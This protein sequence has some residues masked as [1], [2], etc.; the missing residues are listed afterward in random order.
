MM[1]EPMLVRALATSIACCLL[2]LAGCSAIANSP[3]TVGVCLVRGGKVDRT[4]VRQSDC[5]QT[6]GTW[7][8]R[9]K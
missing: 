3:A 9:P 8:A 7:E 6:G 1:K 4:I 5:D 2:V